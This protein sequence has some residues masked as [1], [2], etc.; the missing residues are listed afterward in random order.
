MI[1]CILTPT[2]TNVEQFQL[3]D[4][5]IKSMTADDLLELPMGMGERYE[6]IEG[7][8][9]TMT[10]AG[11]RHGEVCLNIGF[12]I[13]L[14]LKD[15]PIGRAV[16]TETGFFTRSD[17]GT[18]RAPDVAFIPH[19][20]IP[21]DGLPQGYL[22]I[23]PAIVAEVVSPHDRATDVKQKAQEWLQFDVDVVWIV[24]PELQ[25]VE[26]YRHHKQMVMMTTTDMIT[27]DAILPEFSVSVA[28][29]F[30]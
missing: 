15:H 2:Y 14:Y 20:R 5:N 7:E 13:K 19:D 23:I 17:N 25:S 3:A 9:I 21:P 30:E 11:G 8:L 6:L 10:P 1:G 4:L 24:Y 27:A 29:F 28:T 18:V 16:G 22:A 12:Q 26:I